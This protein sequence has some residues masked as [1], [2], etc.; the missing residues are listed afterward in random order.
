M[1]RRLTLFIMVGFV[2]GIVAGFALN[3]GFA[4]GDPALAQ[5]ADYL[6]LLPD[7]FLRLIKMIIAPLVFGTIVSGIA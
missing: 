2:L 3:H 6:K 1:G 5:W 7:V 4:A